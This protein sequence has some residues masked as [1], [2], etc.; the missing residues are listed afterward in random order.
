MSAHEVEKAPESRPGEV[1]LPFEASLRGTA[2][3][4]EIV[5][6]MVRIASDAFHADLRSLALT[7]IAFGFLLLFDLANRAVYL[8][9]HYSDWGVLPRSVLLELNW[10]SWYVSL[11]LLSGQPAVQAVLFALALENTF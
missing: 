11:H 5:R 7:R 9:A 6:K 10:R 4:H 1:S 2:S 8:E 3:L